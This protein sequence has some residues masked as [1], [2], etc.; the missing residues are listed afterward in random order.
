MRRRFLLVLALLAASLPSAAGA[1]LYAYDAS[2][3]DVIA[4]GV[5][6]GGVE[7]G[8]LRAD[9]ARAVL[10][11]ELAPR[12][13]QPLQLVHRGRRF[14]VSPPELELE[15]DVGRMV[16]E[17]LAA[18]RRGNLVRRSLRYVTGG[19]VE[20]DLGHRVR[21]S[22]AAV[23]EVVAR[24]Q[25]RLERRPRNAR[26]VPSPTRLRTVKSRNGVAVPV[27]KLRRAVEAELTRAGGERTIG[28]PTSVTTPRVTTEELAER[29]PA[30]ITISRDQK[31]LRLFRRLRLAKTYT[32]AIGQAG[33][34]TPA[35]LYRIQTKAI[36][37][38]WYVPNK[39]WAGSLAGRV[40]P[41]GSP[42]NP[43]RARWM[44]FHDGAGIHGTDDIASLGTAASHGCIRM[45]IPDVVELF[46]RV[47]LRTPLFIG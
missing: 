12:L 35:G 28:V 9:A 8:G 34:E 43:I 16:A 10:A 37:P 2:R 29:Y 45:S 44:G 46:E 24:V 39:P 5:A 42:D 18:S 38:A 25:R 6:V 20:A 13:E 1:A 21:Y 22:R 17:A 47:P 33:F 11:R 3:D 7:L 14:R 4:D 23:A 41:A 32:V 36:N 19:G 30:F 15:A 31:R 40:I 27:G 26:L